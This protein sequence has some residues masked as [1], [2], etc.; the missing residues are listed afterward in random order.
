MD[1]LTVVGGNAIVSSGGTLGGAST[2][3]TLSGGMLEIM[4][5]GQVAASNQIVFAG[6]GTL[7][8]DNSQIFTSASPLS[9][10]G[11]GGP[12]HTDPDQIDLADIARSTAF[13]LA[14]T[15]SGLSS[16]TLTIG[17]FAGTHTAS[18]LLFGHYTALNFQLSADSG[19]GTIVSDPPSEPTTSSLLAFVHS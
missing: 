12:N 14:Y 17:D 19:G 18:L 7:K 10:S 16:G 5:G 13:V 4:S 3:T 2:A 8:L 15:G 11:F 1:T 9:I 6:S